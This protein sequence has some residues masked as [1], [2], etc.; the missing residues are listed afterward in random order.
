MDAVVH[1][2]VN[3]LNLQPT[4][5]SAVLVGK[6][7]PQS[8][9]GDSQPPGRISFTGQD[10]VNIV[11]DQSPPGHNSSDPSNPVV[12]PLP[13]AP[14]ASAPTE[15]AVAPTE[16]VTPAPVATEDATAVMTPTDAT[17]RSAEATT[18]QPS[19]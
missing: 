5:T 18:D 3:Q 4:D 1:I 9:A 11:P 12:I 2:E 14:P 13:T 16:E 19:G 6:T 17:E 8:V 7:F 10:F 15:D